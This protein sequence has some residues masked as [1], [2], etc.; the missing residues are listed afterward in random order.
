MG[1]F[2]LR[3]IAL[4][5]PVV[6]GITLAVFFLIRLIP[7]DP[8]RTLL[9]IHATPELIASVRRTLGLD[10]SVGVQYL[11]FLKALVHGDLGHSYFFSSDVSSL[12]FARL[13]PTIFLLTYATLLTVLIA[14]PSAILAA[15]RPNSIWDQAVRFVSIFGIGL[16]SY[17]LG[18][19]LVYA[20]AIAIPILPV[21]GYGENFGEHLTF[22]LLPALTIAVSLVPLVLRALRAS[23]METLRAGFVDTARAKGL[24]WRIVLRRHVVRNALMPAI[25]VLALNIGYL[26]GGT[27][28]IE[29][30]FAIPGVGQLMINSIF[31]R[32][33]PVVQGVTLVFA[34]LVVLVNLLADLA[35]AALDPRV[36]FDR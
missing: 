16:P 12:V 24:A 23:V 21:A 9:G 13:P 1:A 18:V 30:V 27:V 6:L 36:R 5:V 14:F 33:F 2:L 34:V 32:D 17:W 22:L 26:I 4:L 7:G 35:Y 11:I 31:Q 15:L 28:I 3:R 25:T 29:N 19:V 20:F 8:A 10:Q